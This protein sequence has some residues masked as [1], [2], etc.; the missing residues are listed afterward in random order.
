MAERTHDLALS[1]ARYRS[2]VE[3][4]IAAI[5]QLDLQAVVTYAN[6]AF[7]TLMG[8]PVEQLIGRRMADLLPPAK[9]AD[10]T[11]AHLNRR[12]RGEPPPA[13]VV[14]V[15]FAAPSGRLVP[16]LMGLRVIHD[17]DGRS[18]GVTVL[19]LDISDRRTLEAAL[20]A[21]RDRLDAILFNIGDAVVV[22]DAGGTIEYVNP[23]WERLN[24]YTSE[25]AVGQPASILK[26]GQHTREVY[27]DLWSTVM[28]GRGWHGE[29]V[30]RR[31]DGSTYDVALTVTPLLDPK[32]AVSH[33]V[34][35]LYDISALKEVDRLKTQFVSDVSHE[36]RT[37]LT[38]IRLYLDLLRTTSDRMKIERYL[39]TL[40]RESDRLAHL[41]DD[42]LSLSRLDSGATVLDLRP[43]DL[44][45]LLRSLVDDRRNLAANRGLELQLATDPTLPLAMGDE[46]LLTQVFT[47][48]LTNAINYTPDHGR[49][50]LRT[51][52]SDGEHG[53]G[54]A[55]DVEDTGPGIP[56]EEQ[57]QLFRRFFRGRA[58]RATGAAGTGLGLAICKEI[59]DR[60]GGRISLDSGRAPGGGTRFTVW[61]PTG[62]VIARRNPLAQLNGPL[63]A[64]SQMCLAWKPVGARHA[65]LRLHTY[66]GVTASF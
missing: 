35:V 41:I 44:N 24:G 48:L 56:L 19:V 36:L 23:A 61:I 2:L 38:N 16:A 22:T 31:K 39:D 5:A 12:L 32:G 58:G 29:F 25:E 54:V 1:E 13:D 63:A 30:N 9:S 45:R 28:S 8:R 14:E 50:M 26:S 20:R 60:H 34:A 52:L 27:S 65:S 7:A 21:E 10:E 42:L 43:V 47:N 46:R 11:M 4:S 40:S 37:P 3:T 64:G 55:T 51:Y 57:P 18:Q 15:D 59:V 66:L 53:S 49:V 6:Q 17:E 33:I 62:A